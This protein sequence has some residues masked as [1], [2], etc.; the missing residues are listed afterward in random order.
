[1]THFLHANRCPLRLKSNETFDLWDSC[2]FGKLSRFLSE[3]RRF[4]R[5]AGGLGQ[6]MGRFLCK[7]SAKSRASS[8]T[9]KPCCLP[10]S[11]CRGNIKA[12]SPVRLV[13]MPREAKFMPVSMKSPIC[14]STASPRQ[15]CHGRA[16]GRSYRSNAGRA[17]GLLAYYNELCPFLFNCSEE[18]H[19]YPRPAVQAGS[20]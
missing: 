8:S 18:G 19:G 16:G 7:S 15:K 12:R 2:R 14:S 3:N 5:A 4:R 17:V 1:L 9:E 13:T 6:V 10:G 20:R 11:C